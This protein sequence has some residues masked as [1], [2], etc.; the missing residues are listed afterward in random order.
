MA[1]KSALGLYKGLQS[2][3]INTSVLSSI[4]LSWAINFKVTVEKHSTL[5]PANFST[6]NFDRHH[7]SN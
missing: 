5:I 6:L 3:I 4:L 1:T 2:S 7:V